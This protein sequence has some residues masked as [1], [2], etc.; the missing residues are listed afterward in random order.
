MNL[1]R[2]IIWKIVEVLHYLLGF[3]L[4]DY[5]EKKNISNGKRIYLLTLFL[6]LTSY[7]IYFL[8]N[9]TSFYKKTFIHLILIT[10][11]IDEHFIAIISVL[12]EI[13]LIS[14][15]NNEV[16]QKIHKIDEYMKL[17]R[18]TKLELKLRLTTLYLGYIIFTVFILYWDISI[19]GFCLNVFMAFFKEKA[20]DM[21]FFKFTMMAHLHLCRLCLM[22]GHLIKKINSNFNYE[23]SNWLFDWKIHPKNIEILHYIEDLNVIIKIYSSLCE[24]MVIIS[25]IFKFFVSTNNII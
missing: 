19:W 20:F 18:D 17:D 9:E 12:T 10:V 22:N 14:L 16:F 8:M 15:K 7:T 25:K 2:K 5:L 1:F 23:K 21:M 13:L 11:L 4:V 3:Q 24:N 6:I